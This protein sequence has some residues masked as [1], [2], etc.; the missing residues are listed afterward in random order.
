MSK[1]HLIPFNKMSKERQRELS[2]RGGSVKSEAKRTAAWLRWQKQNGKLTDEGFQFVCNMLQSP[3]LSI[4]QIAKMA[5]R[6]LITKDM[7]P[8]QANMVV[9][10]ML[11]IHKAHHGDKV[12]TENV[13]H[14]IDWTSKLES[15]EIKEE[16][17]T[18]PEETS[19]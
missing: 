12:K 18:E 5:N 4:A 15:L 13:H 19:K 16:D 8:K 17:G 14:V 2:A 11:S 10:T 6:Y 9:N 7:S 1:E 3:E